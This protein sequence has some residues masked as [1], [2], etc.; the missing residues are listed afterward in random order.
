MAFNFNE[1]TSIS[2]K[3]TRGGA[4]IAPIVRINNT[5]TGKVSFRLSQELFNELGLDANS[6]SAK[7]SKDGKQIFLAVSPGNEGDFFKSRGGKVKGNT[8][9]HKELGDFL[10][11]AGMTGNYFKL[12]KAGM[13]E[14]IAYYQVLEASVD[15]TAPKVKK[16]KVPAT[17]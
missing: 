5:K 10:N 8:A 4:A 6:L 3:I 7:H 14:G 16:E 17:V 2:R 13:A 9:E 15:K 11:K 12:E 1:L